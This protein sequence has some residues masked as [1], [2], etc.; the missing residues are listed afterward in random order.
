MRLARSFPAAILA[1]AGAALAPST[2]DAETPGEVEAPSPMWKRVRIVAID[3]HV[4]L[5]RVPT[6]EEREALSPKYRDRGVPLCRPP[7][8]KTIDAS[9][10]VFYVE[11]PAGKYFDESERFRLDGNRGD[12]TL[13][14][15]DRSVHGAGIALTVA[16][17]VGTGVGL[18][19]FP[20]SYLVYLGG[21]YLPGQ[22][23]DHANQLL[24]SAQVLTVAGL[25][26][27]IA[28]FVT[29]SASKIR[30]VEVVPREHP[31]SAVRL[32]GLTLRF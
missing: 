21:G 11:R 25:A 7:C 20:L 22:Q 17:G 32:D 8:D 31:E 3:P 23:H 2:A 14:V 15:G 28:G 5:F 27:L 29:I 13:R 30:H 16:G 1:L 9:G 12:V 4:I 10:G 6:P 18:T 24:W 19:L 26:T